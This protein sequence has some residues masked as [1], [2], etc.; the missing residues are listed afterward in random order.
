MSSRIKTLDG[1]RGLAVLLVLLSHTLGFP[2]GGYLGV[3]IFFVVSGFIIA[4]NILDGK[5]KDISDFYNKRIKRIYPPLFLTILLIILFSIVRKSSIALD[6]VKYILTYTT[7]LIFLKEE[8]T[9]NLGNV[10]TYSPISHLWSLSIEEQF[11]LFA[12]A[13]F[14]LLHR[15]KFIYLYILTIFS[16]IFYL[17]NIN[18]FSSD[19]SYFSTI[20][21]VWEILLGVL[22]ATFLSKINIDLKNRDKISVLILGVILIFSIL[23]EYLDVKL[24]QF[25]ISLLT[26][27]IILI[28][29]NKILDSKVSVFIGSISYGVYLFH[30]PLSYYLMSISESIL[31][32]FLTIFL[33]ITLATISFYLLEDKI[34]KSKVNLRKSLTMVVISSLTL[35]T[36]NHG[37]I[38]FIID[39][40]NTSKIYT[41]MLEKFCSGDKINCFN[42]F[43]INSNASWWKCIDGYEFDR[44][45]RCLVYKGGKNKLM[46]FGDSVVMSFIPGIVAEAG[47]NYDV[48]SNITYGC[49]Y[50]KADESDIFQQTEKAKSC[51]EEIEGSFRYIEEIK[52]D[53]V[54]IGMNSLNR[55]VGPIARNERD[56]ENEY[57]NIVKYSENTI[58]RLSK[59]T[60]KIIVFIPPKY[61]DAKNCINPSDSLDKCREDIGVRE[62]INKTEIIHQNIIFDLKRKNNYVTIVDTR[63]VTC[64]P[65]LKKCEWENELGQTRSS[66]VH[67]TYWLSFKVAEFIKIKILE[68]M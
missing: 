46:V 34:I 39:G 44:Y 49:G 9:Y 29:R 37:A 30:I 18:E 14:F 42:N 6:Y 7:N 13:L 55:Y 62:V 12:P 32:K 31:F 23:S 24:S 10:V 51:N 67:L 1:L 47:S 60:K 68:K 52:P 56:S 5:Y 8:A 20:G 33:S 59:I 57:E 16:F 4:K 40:K 65:S 53:V 27:L 26:S 64:L 36:L 28:G 50:I 54:V 25:F 48:Y 21:R 45:N 22:T 61:L 19:S 11:Y 41:V 3:D 17:L 38:K 58:K 66:Q 43:T 35:I 15:R 63:E 2:K